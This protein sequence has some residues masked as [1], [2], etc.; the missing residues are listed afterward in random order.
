MF[1]IVY[2]T[3]FG[4]SMAPE[5]F[6][7]LTKEVGVVLAQLGMDITIHLDNWLIMGPSAGSASYMV[8]TTLTSKQQ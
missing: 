3:T 4:F 1:Q 6:T 7:K 8:S 2:G 5:V